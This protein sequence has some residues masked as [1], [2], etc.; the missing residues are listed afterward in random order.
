MADFFAQL[1]LTPREMRLLI[2]RYKYN[3][4]RQD[5]ILILWISKS[6]YH[7][8]LSWL[9]D[10]LNKNRRKKKIINPKLRHWTFLIEN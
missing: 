8:L 10:K 4:P 6:Y 9:T 3:L 7:I 2:L 5:I 1:E